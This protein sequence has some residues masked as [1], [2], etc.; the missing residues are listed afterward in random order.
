MLKG[1]E[2]DKTRPK[3]QEADLPEERRT[4]HYRAL[5]CKLPSLPDDP[6]WG[7]LG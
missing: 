7:G 2:N 6:E 3:K 5:W 1:G 4:D